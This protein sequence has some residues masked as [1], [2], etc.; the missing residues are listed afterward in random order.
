MERNVRPELKQFDSL[1][2]GI[3]GIPYL[4]F[5]HQGGMRMA[6]NVTTKH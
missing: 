3:G 1:M 5:L 2:S 4:Y 6:N